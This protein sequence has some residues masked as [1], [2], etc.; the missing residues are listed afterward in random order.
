MYVRSKLCRTKDFF[1]QDPGAGET[2]RDV[3]RLLEFMVNV[4]NKYWPS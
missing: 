3:S 2:R 4:S 1:R